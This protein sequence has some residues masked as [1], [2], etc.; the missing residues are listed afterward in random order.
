MITISK[1]SMKSWI[2]YSLFFMLCMNVNA[3]TFIGTWKVKCLIEREEAG[4]VKQS[5]WCE[6][7]TALADEGNAKQLDWIWVWKQDKILFIR[8][9]DTTEGYFSYIAEMGSIMIVKDGLPR[10]YKLFSDFEAGRILLRD[11]D[12][13]LLYLTEYKKGK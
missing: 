6:D 13:T 3:Q 12:M 5:K 9:N 1:Y 2:G 4:K 11:E 10:Q 8:G 7:Y